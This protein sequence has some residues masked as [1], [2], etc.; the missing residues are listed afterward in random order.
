MYCPYL[1]EALSAGLANYVASTR[2]RHTRVVLREGEVMAFV[3]PVSL[4]AR[5][6]AVCGRGAVT[7]LVGGLE[8]RSGWFQQS[9]LAYKSNQGQCHQAADWVYG[10]PPH[11]KKEDDPQPAACDS[12]YCM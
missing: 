2:G 8:S 9:V 3:D 7:H 1:L 5:C 11:A 6:D 4:A 12:L 10:K